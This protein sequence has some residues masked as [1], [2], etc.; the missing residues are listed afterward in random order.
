MTF[1][2]LA[3]GCAPA[4][5][6]AAPEAVGVV[7]AGLGG[8]VSVLLSNA[9]GQSRRFAAAAELR[10]VAS[11]C[12]AAA[13][14]PAGATA[15]SP[16]YAITAGH[17]VVDWSTAAAASRPTLDAAVDPMSVVFHRF[18]DTQD[19]AQAVAV[20][21]VLF[22]TMK[23]TDL[24]VLELDA[25]LGDLAA[26]DVAP[27][28]LASRV[29]AG[30]AV[31]LAGVPTGGFDEAELHLRLSEGRLLAPA[32]VLEGRWL[33]PVTLPFRAPSI[34]PGISGA[35]V[36][37][38]SGRVL[39]VVST[40][41]QGA[42]GSGC[43][44]GEPCEVTAAG[45]T[46]RPDRSYASPV[47]GLG[48]CFD[49]RGRFALGG[50][51]GLDDGFGVFAE[52]APAPRPLPPRLG[53]APRPWGVVLSGD[54]PE[55]RAKV[56]PLGT[57]DCRRLEGYGPPV[58]RDAF[59]YTTAAV[60]QADGAYVLCLLGTDG[61]R[62]QRWPT[63]IP[64]TVDGT[65]PTEAPRYEVRPEAD[66]VEVELFFAPPELAAYRVRSGPAASTSCDAMDSAPLYRFFPLWIP[67]EALPGRVCVAAEDAA[68]NLGATLAIAVPAPAP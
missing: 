25:T 49:G 35:P 2:A 53:G 65:P 48:R 41:T 11:A 64:L 67:R 45:A 4:A 63:A 58:A 36:L 62:V 12:S 23:G 56:G 20:R 5:D 68:G 27:F 6:D 7:T 50:A 10:T 60:P 14:A 66:G 39:G 15:E 9:A 38:T 30:A 33:W 26:L 8:D 54:A 47:V 18:V 24:A 31:R 40:T 17:C 22:A 52:E 19:R 21:R 55:V 28:P 3:C 44:V 29:A 43:G 51:C 57:T 46:L 61:G 59:G 13:I 42:E 32:A 16:A 1:A 34:V 37:D